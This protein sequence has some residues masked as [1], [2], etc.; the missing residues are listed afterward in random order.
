MSLRNRFVVPVIFS[1]LALLAGCGSSSP[2]VTPPPTGGFSNSNLNGTYVFTASGTD[3]DGD[4]YAIAGTLTANGSGGITGGAVDVSDPA[5]FSPEANVA[6]GSGSSYSVGVDG[7]GTAILKTSTSFGTITLAFV[8]QDS[9]HG[10]VIQFD[11][12]ASGSGTLDVQTAGTTPSG[13]YAFSFFGANS[14]GDLATVGNFTVGSGGSITGLQDLTNNTLVYPNLALSGAL[15]PGPSSSPATTL[16]TAS[17]ALVFDAIPI[18]ATHL[19]F[20]E[21]DS[22]GTL[23]GDAY[24]QTSSSMPVGTLPFTV[25]GA[26]TSSL[27]PTVAGGFMVTDSSGDITNA[28]S[29]DVNE[30]G[31]TINTAPI[32]FSGSYTAGGT[33]RYVLNVT[34]FQGAT[35]FVAY[36]SSAGLFLLQSDSQGILSGIAYPAQTSTTFSSGQGYGL[37]LSGDNVGDGVEVDNI[38]E[39][40]AA[41]GGGVTGYLDENYAPSGMPNP[42]VTLGT[43]SQFTTPTNGRGQ[44]TT[45]SESITTLNGGF[46]LTYYT[47]DGT[48]VPFIESDNGQVA[49]GVM[50][51]QN[52]SSSAAAL[53]KASGKHLYVPLH[54]LRSRK[55]QQKKK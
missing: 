1:G 48:T 15:V 35:Q 2:S 34:G 39:F 43:T 41:S 49:L 21:M 28:S 27:E 6:I 33:G 10:L 40:T 4:P 32:T 8:L 44:I 38:A 22:A 3:T 26:I 11:Q 5:A 25:G 13:T 47:V 24:S 54:M 46:L 19:K 42:N 14:T 50:V 7:R 51:V 30:G 45:G 18:D 20:I 37:N 53:A 52:A 9:S 23:S 55:A 12:N 36:P 16:T 31:S 17:F 29:Q